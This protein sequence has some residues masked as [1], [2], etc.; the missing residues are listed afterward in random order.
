[1]VHSLAW[2]VVVVDKSPQF[3]TMWTSLWGC[4]IVLVTGQLASPRASHAKERQSGSHNV[5]HD[6]ASEIIQAFL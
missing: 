5:F 2:L 6:P 4:L 1:M 3:L